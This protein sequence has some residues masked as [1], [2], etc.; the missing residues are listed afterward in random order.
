MDEL[1]VA[2]ATDDGE[3]FVGCHFGA[4]EYYDVYNLTPTGYEFILRVVNSIDEELG[5]GDPRK[6]RGIVSILKK[7]GV[8]VGLTRRFGP[9]IKRIKSK[10]VCVLTGHEVVVRGLEMI[11][12]NFESIAAEWQKGDERTILD[13]RKN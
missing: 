13:L 5:H 4:A 11:C 3:K 10:I 9:N 12:E 8:Q 7:E 2:V 6:A 1:R